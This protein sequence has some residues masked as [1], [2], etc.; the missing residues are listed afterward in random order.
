MNKS[1]SNLSPVKQSSE[2]DG[3]NEGGSSVQDATVRED[4][5]MASPGLPRAT[6]FNIEFGQAEAR[7]ASLVLKKVEEKLWSEV[8]V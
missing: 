8:N 6:H 1:P 2:F 7:S 5:S 3:Q 4:E